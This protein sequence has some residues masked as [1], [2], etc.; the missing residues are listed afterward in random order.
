MA[1]L[2]RMNEDYLLKEIREAQE[3]AERVLSDRAEELVRQLRQ[4]VR[5]TPMPLDPSID[6]V[7]VF[8]KDFEVEPGFD[9]YTELFNGELRFSHQVRDEQDGY[10]Q[11]YLPLI[12]HERTR[13]PAGRYR[14]TLIISKLEE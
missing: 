14:V 10:K 8:V 11:D 6:A 12:R 13:F 2:K 5:A 9:A 4:A 7:A 3:A 1:E